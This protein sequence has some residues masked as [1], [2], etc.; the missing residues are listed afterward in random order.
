MRDPIEALEA[1]CE[2]LEMDA[3]YHQQELEQVKAERDAFKARITKA[4]ELLEHAER[5]DAPLVDTIRQAWRML[6]GEA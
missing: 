3:R 5:V 4:T 2:T 6:E 1:K